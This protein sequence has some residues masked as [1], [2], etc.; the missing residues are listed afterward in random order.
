M[1][2]WNK[3]VAVATIAMMSLTSLPLQAAQEEN[4]AHYKQPE[5]QNIEEVN[6]NPGRAYSD[7]SYMWGWRPEYLLYAA[8]IGVGIYIAIKN[9]DSGHA[10]T[11]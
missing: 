5:N 10:H 4:Q 8:V 2:L 7:A 11:H 3:M 6:E 9:N 1:K